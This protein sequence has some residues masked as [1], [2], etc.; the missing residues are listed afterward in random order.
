[1]SSDSKKQQTVRAHMQGAKGKSP[2]YLAQRYSRALSAWHARLGQ[3]VPLYAQESA[4]RTDGAAEVVA[5]KLVSRVAAEKMRQRAKPDENGTDAE[6]AGVQEIVGGSYEE[7]A[8]ALRL[9]AEGEEPEGLHLPPQLRYRGFEEAEEAPGF[10]V[11]LD[12]LL[13]LSETGKLA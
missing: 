3:P 4:A 11:V 5:L 13:T 7:T 8:E 9:V 2:R 12:A 1:M 10:V 6:R